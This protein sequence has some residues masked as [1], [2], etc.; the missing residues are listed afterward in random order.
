MA[1][2]TIVGLYRD[3]AEAERV[4]SELTSAGFDRSD[5]SIIGRDDRATGGVTAESRTTEK[6]S[7]VSTGAGAAIGAG[8]GAAIGGGLGLLAGAA[9]F[10][11]PGIGPLLGIGPMAATIIGG[12]GIGAAAGGI[13]GALVN[14]GVPHEEAERYTAGVHRG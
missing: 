7:D 6:E 10:F 3:H 4:V 5:I 12:A 11:I 13:A 2:R 1:K 14:S 8:T 9:G